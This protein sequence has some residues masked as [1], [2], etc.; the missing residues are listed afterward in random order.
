MFGSS[1]LRRRRRHVQFD[2]EAADLSLPAAGVHLEVSVLFQ[3][4]NGD[5]RRLAIHAE[6]FFSPAIGA[7]RPDRLDQSLE[8]LACCAGAER[9]AEI[10]AG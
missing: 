9:T 3:R 5:E 8:F 2:S 10:G 7:D 4:P 1:D 6:A